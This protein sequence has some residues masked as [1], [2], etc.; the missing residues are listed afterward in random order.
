MRGTQKY[1]ILVGTSLSRFSS[2]VSYRFFHHNNITIP[3]SSNKPENT[4]EP[5]LNL[6]NTVK[7]TGSLFEPREFNSEGAKNM[8]QEIVKRLE[9]DRQNRPMNSY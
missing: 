4:S 2:T 8:T 1:S 5:K 3:D 7:P 9:E 6:N